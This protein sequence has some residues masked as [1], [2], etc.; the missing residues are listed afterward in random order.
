MKILVGG[1]NPPEKYARQ[2]GS[3]PQDSGGG[4]EIKNNWN[5][6]QVIK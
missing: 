2:I 3:F 5:H 4:G 1:V 6:Y